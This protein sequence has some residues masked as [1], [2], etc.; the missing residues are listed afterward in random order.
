[1]VGCEFQIDIIISYY[2]PKMPAQ[3]FCTK[4]YGHGI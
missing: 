3:V 4:N 1:L 2:S